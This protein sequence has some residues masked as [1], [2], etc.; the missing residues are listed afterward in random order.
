MRNG[1]Y[2]NDLKGTIFL[3]RP[4]GQISIHG[5]INHNAYE[6]QIEGP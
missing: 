3:D 5:R 6:T 4:F 1:T 2:L